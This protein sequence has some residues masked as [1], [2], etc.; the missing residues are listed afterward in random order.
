M[1]GLLG[2]YPQRFC[3]V[4]SVAFMLFPSGGIEGELAEEKMENTNWVK[5]VQQI[6]ADLVPW[7]LF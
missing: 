6:N 3:G 4:G 2:E 1:P 7:S 5:L